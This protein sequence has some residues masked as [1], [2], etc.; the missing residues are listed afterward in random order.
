[1]IRFRLWH[2]FV[3]VAIAAIAL[4]AVDQYARK[5]IVLKFTYARLWTDADRQSLSAKGDYFVM[6][7]ITDPDNPEWPAECFATANFG[8]NSLLS[9]N[10]DEKNLREIA[11]T[12][13]TVVLRRKPF[14]WSPMCHA[15]DVL[16]E[17]FEYV[18]G[19]P[20]VEHQ[21]IDAG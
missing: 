13:A 19:L 12:S 5:I 14:L 1:M 16:S 18:H 3:V 9:K 11:N 4:F 6:F 20:D 10:V 17:H 2:L 8:H 7:T 15:N 21:V